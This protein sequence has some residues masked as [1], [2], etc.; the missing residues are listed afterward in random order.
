MRITQKWKDVSERQW[1]DW[2]WQMAN[3]LIRIEELV[4]VV[5][6]LQNEIGALK[7]NASTF[8]FAITPYYAH[9]SATWDENRPLWKQV[10]PALQECEK[11]DGLSL[12]P[13]AEERDTPVSGL[14][15]RYENRVLLLVTNKCAVYCRFCN[16]RRRAEGSEGDATGG[17]I[18]GWLEYLRNHNEVHEVIL[19]GGDPLTLTDENLD[20][21]LGSLREIPSIQII[22]LCSRMPVVLPFRVTTELCEILRRYQPLYLNIHVNHPSELTDEMRRACELLA[23]TGVPLGSQAVLLRGINDDVSILKELFTRL[24]MLRI[25]PYSLYHG[26][27]VQ[28][29]AHF[30][31]S[32]ARGQEIMRVL[33]A[34]LSGLAVPHYVLDA[35]E[36]QGKIP[37]LPEFVQNEEGRVIQLRSLKGE[38]MRYPD[39]EG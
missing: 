13:L 39:G 28:G 24:L 15:H 35:P 2:K 20:D 37:I 14:V 22:R 17:E 5:P 6:D 34:E 10:I 29:T 33:I 7:R 18:A 26:D 23:D 9:L 25:K 1:S 38:S 36:G 11:F 4:G 32:I 19:S 30:R 31:T 16:R 12:D 21:L 27:P 8:R 3:R